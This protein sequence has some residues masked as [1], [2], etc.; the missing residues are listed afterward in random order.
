M[1]TKALLDCV[2]ELQLLSTGA[3]SHLSPAWVM[4]AAKHYATRLHTLS[5]TILLQDQLALEVHHLGTKR[6]P[7]E[8][9]GNLNLTKLFD[10]NN[11]TT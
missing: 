10:R 6:E 2:S 9:V 7:M 8:M 5:H 3:A 11:N 4:A 1:F